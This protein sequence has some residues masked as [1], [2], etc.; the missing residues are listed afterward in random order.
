MGGVCERYE[1]GVGR[2][3]RRFF[4]KKESE[5]KE[6]IKICQVDNFHLVTFLFTTIFHSI[7]KYA[8]SRNLFSIFILLHLS[9]FSF[10]RV[11]M[12]IIFFF[13]S[14]HMER[15]ESAQNLF[16]QVLYSSH[17]HKSSTERRKEVKGKGIK[18]SLYFRE[19]SLWKEKSVP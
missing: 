15:W 2:W 16:C 1:G 18:K 7:Y 6:V 3:A 4:R 11:H 14:T 8:N 19:F 10:L 12:Y 17:Q 9:I 13:E 5:S